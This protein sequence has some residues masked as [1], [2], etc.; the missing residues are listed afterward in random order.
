MPTRHMTI[1]M[2]R[3]RLLT[4]SPLRLIRSSPGTTTQGIAT[5]SRVGNSQRQAGPFPATLGIGIGIGVAIAIGIDIVSQPTS[6]Q[7]IKNCLE[8]DADCD[9]DTDPV[10]GEIPRYCS[11]KEAR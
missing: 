8:F 10:M 5:V 6:M 9:P 2:D 3:G 7:R 11:R 1:D 4:V